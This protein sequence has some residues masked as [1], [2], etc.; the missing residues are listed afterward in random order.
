MSSSPE[1]KT[2][3]LADWSRAD[4]TATLPVDAI[5]L[6]TTMTELIRTRT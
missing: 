4:A 3:T 1:F 6:G 2:A 5:E